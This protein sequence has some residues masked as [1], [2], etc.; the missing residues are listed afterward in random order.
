[1]SNDESD[2]IF[3]IYKLSSS[4]I[5]EKNTWSLDEISTHITNN[6]S[7]LSKPELMDRL[8]GILKE[9]E[10]KQAVIFINGFESINLDEP[11]LFEIVNVSNKS[12]IM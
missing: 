11:K 9:L 12:K 7:L 6:E 5:P 10:G 2:I 4:I 1:M 3:E 8:R